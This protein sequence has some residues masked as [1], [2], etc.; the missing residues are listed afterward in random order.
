MLKVELT[1][2]NQTIEKD[3]YECTRCRMNTLDSGNL[4][5]PCGRWFNCKAMLVGTIEITSTYKPVETPQPVTN[6]LDVE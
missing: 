6:F 5:I 2:K 1:E 3:Y 4:M